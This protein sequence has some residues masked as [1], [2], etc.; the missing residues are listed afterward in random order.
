MRSFGSLIDEKLVCSFDWEVTKKY[1]QT[2]SLHLLKNCKAWECFQGAYMPTMNSYQRCLIYRQVPFIW[3]IG[4][5]AEWISEHKENVSASA[6][7]Q[8]PAE[9][10][11]PSPCCIPRA[12]SMEIP[13]QSQPCIKAAR[14]LLSCMT[15]KMLWSCIF[16]TLHTS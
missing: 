13:A 14:L 10:Y 2:P 15:L 12:F 3:G 1:R 4:A 8:I 5:E 6:A 9:P 7:A 16:L 11:H